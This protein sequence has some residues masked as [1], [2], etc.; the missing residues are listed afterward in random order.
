MYNNVIIT[1]EK[2][3]SKAKDENLNETIKKVKKRNN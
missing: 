3:P 2:M 1:E